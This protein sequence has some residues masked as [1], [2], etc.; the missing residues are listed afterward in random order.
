MKVP[1]R[2]VYSE[3]GIPDTQV[4]A[5]LCAIHYPGLR[6]SGNDLDPIDFLVSVAMSAYA[7]APR[8]V[9]LTFFTTMLISVLC[10]VL[11]SKEEGLRHWKFDN[12]LCNHLTRVI[13]LCT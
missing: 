3:Y 9:K 6:R 8:H 1:I 12:A 7:S 4:P 2:R 5:H 11:I 10:Y 13:H